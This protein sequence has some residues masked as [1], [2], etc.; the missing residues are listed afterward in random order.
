MYKLYIATN[1]PEAHLIAGMLAGAGIEAQVLNQYSQ[2]AL[3]EIPFGEARPE[4]W[5]TDARDMTIA[6]KM[7]AAY[8]RPAGAVKNT[9]CP[10]CGED[11]PADF[12]LCWN[13][14]ASL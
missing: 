12:G 11:N 9:P 3:G 7:I 8:E 13:C 6:Q 4:L 10:T 5:L 1:L 2:S 14:G